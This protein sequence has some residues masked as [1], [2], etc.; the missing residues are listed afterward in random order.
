LDLQGNV[1]QF[2]DSF[3]QM[4]GYTHGETAR[5]N[6]CA[7]EAQIPRAQLS[8]EIAK[9]ICTAAKF[10]TLHRRKDG[11]IY[12][13]EINAKGV[14]LDGVPYLYASVRDIS[15]R[16]A[17][18]RKL[19]ASAQEIEDLYNHAPCGYHSLDADGLYQ[20]VND[21]ELE[22]LECSREEVI[23]KMRATDFFTPEGQALF[24]QH[25]PAFIQR[26]HVENLEFQ[27][28]GKKGGIRHVG[29]SATALR[30]AE[31]RY[32]M[33]RS[34]FYDISQIKQIEANLRRLTLEQHAMLDND[35]V[36]IAKLQGR[37]IVW[38]NKAMERIFGYAA[39]AMIGKTTQVFYPDADAF[40]AFGEEAYAVLGARGVYRR[41]MEMARQDGGRIWV[42]VSGVQ[43]SQDSQESLWMLADITPLK[44]HQDEVEQIAYHDTLTGLPNRLLFFD[45]LHQALAQ[46]KRLDCCV[47]IC[48]LDLD[49]FKPIND[50]F[51]HALGDKLLQ[52]IARRMQASIRAI[53]TVARMGGDEFVLLLTQLEAAGE[54]QEILQRVIDAINRPVALDAA[55]SGKVTA[56]IGITL[57]PADGSDA[58]TLLRHADQAMYQAKK[59]G[60][61]RIRLY[62]AG[63]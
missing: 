25:F 22:W 10:E 9:L 30:D 15:K 7:W 54:H 44:R 13:A 32:L 36:G 53:D 14:V 41:Q 46:A 58:D 39:D 50:Q 33:S 16:K 42:D 6:V 11:S 34:V 24:Q 47:A 35:L 26:G 49:E 8:S 19:A 20:R 1:V 61:N 63:L 29:L 31:G 57:F 60:R 17:L 52:E 2:S 40:Q 5:L 48:Y 51:G 12:E 59:L 38:L 3:A 18:E 28:M 62:A 56:S 55:R 21:T 37:R 4:L 45:R 43:L 23:G 27:L